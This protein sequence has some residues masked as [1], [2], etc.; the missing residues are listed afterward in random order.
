[1]AARLGGA[2]LASVVASLTHTTAAA[3]VNR[4]IDDQQGDSVTGQLPSKFPADKWANGQQCPSCGIRPGSVVD[5]KQTFRRTWSDSTYKPGQPD[6]VINVSFTGTAVYVYN[7]IV[8]TI[9]EITTMTNLSFSIDGTYMAQYI[10]NPDATSLV[11]YNVSV[12]SHTQLTNRTHLLEMRA[13]GLSESLI[14]F[15]YIVYT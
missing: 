15:D 2:I 6:H 13:S 10:H 12:F 14:L 3:L 1:M 9:P 8:N 7:L 5:P 4:T 11:L